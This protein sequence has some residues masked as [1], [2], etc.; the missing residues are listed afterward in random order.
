M[1]GVFDFDFER[2]LRALRIKFLKGSDSMRSEPDLV[3][4]V[5]ALADR[6]A[7][8]EKQL[9]QFV[10]GVLVTADAPEPALAP[11]PFPHARDIT[12]VQRLSWMLAELYSKARP[13]TDCTPLAREVLLTVANA[14]SLNNWN[15]SMAQRLTWGEAAHW[16][17]RE[18]ALSDG[19]EQAPNREAEPLVQV[20]ESWYSDFADWLEREMPEG[21]VIGDPLWWASRIADRFI[22]QATREAP[23][24]PQ[25][26]ERISVE[27]VADLASAV[28]AGA[29]PASPEPVV[30][31]EISDE[32]LLRTYGL[33]KQNHCYEGPI[34]DWP[35]RAERAATLCGLRA[36]LAR[37]ARPA[38]QPVAVSERL[39]GPE[40]LD[41]EGTCWMFNPIML[42]YCLFRPDPSAHTYWLPHWALPLPAADLPAADQQEGR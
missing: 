7:A 3:A 40:D 30:A 35:K 32:E 17:E 21:T 9:A 37:Y 15:R 19:T 18:A 26:G 5:L 24:V 11:D 16:L 8:L 10:P 33:A 38:I 27:D 41:S 42:Y 34:D 6:V 22:A 2:A 4:I 28:L 39:P 14:V 36:V 25:L 13:S 12:L 1:E 31:A 20:P 29:Q 23:P